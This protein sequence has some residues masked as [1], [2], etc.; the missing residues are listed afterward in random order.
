ME[1]INQYSMLWG[2]V[3]ILGLTAFFLLR[4]GFKRKDGI[5]LLLLAIALLS[6]WLILRPQQAS[7]NEMAD[8]QA[9]LGQGQ[10]VLLEMQSPY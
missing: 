7:T 3:I 10:A 4:K 8:F 2:G 1:I 9:Q 5:K 6:V